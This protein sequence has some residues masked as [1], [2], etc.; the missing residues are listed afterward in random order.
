M[1]YPLFFTTRFIGQCLVGLTTLLLVSC[2]NIEPINI[3]KEALPLIQRENLEELSLKELINIPL[4]EDYSQHTIHQSKTNRVD[5]E[6]VNFGIMAPI[7]EFP[8]Y[9]AEII[10]ASDMAAE[11]INTNGGINGRRLVILRADDKESTPVSAL[12]AEQLIKEHRVEAIIGPAT[13][14][15]VVD[16]LQQVTIPNKVP[17]ISQAASSNVLSEVGGNYQFWRMVANNEQQLKLM[18]DYLHKQL[19]H[20]RVYLMTGRDIYSREIADGLTEYFDS[21]ENGW[22]GQLAISDL[23]HLAEMSFAKEIKSIQEQGVTTIVITLV[24]AQVKD[25]IRKIQQHWSGKYPIIMVGDT[26]TPKYLVDAHLGDINSC[27]FS[28]VGTQSDLKPALSNKISEAIDTI[29]TGFDGAYVFDA[30]MILSMAKILS[31]KFDLSIKQA[32]SLIASDGHPI[33]FTDFAKLVDLYRQH[34]SFS[35]FGYSGRVLFNAKGDNLTAYSKVY[36]I[37]NNPASTREHCITMD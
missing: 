34:K 10:A 3:K 7:S 35:Y 1:C 32:V 29:A 4:K 19:K 17:L 23:V 21:L 22:V 24:N 26:V 31:E 2:A 30:T 20:K 13:S 11:F 33:K 12:L 36:S 18:S 37:G 14:D 27:I 28:Y 25:M 8:V 6:S 5:D 16:V 9:S 15:S